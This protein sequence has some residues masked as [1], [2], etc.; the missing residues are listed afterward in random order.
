MLQLSTATNGRATSSRTTDRIALELIRHSGASARRFL[1]GSD[2]ET[3]GRIRLRVSSTDSGPTAFRADVL[4]GLCA[5]QKTIPCRW[6]YD[7]RGSEL[8]ETITRLPEYYPSRTE[9]AILSS[10]V[11]ALA[12]FVGPEAVVLEYGA[13][14]GIKSRMLLS[15]LRRPRLY[16]PID[17]AGEYLNATVKRMQV[18]FPTLETWPVV[19]DFTADFAMPAGLPGGRR[20][21]FFPGSTIGNLNDSEAGA[22]L[23]RMREHVGP[24]GAAII[25]VDM[26]KD[27]DELLTAYDDPAGVTAEFNLNLLTRINRELG[28]NFNLEAFTHQARW[29]A[30]A[31][32]IEMHL[33]SKIAQT[34][35]VDDERIEFEQGESIHTE[36][37][38][39]YDYQTF[40]TLAA[41][42]G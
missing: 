13:G 38:R 15:A 7:R 34:V 28:G 27:I 19:S 11:R 2:P 40:G 14:A 30:R 35:T 18:D 3:F 21:A 1:V 16:L 24:D 29:N 39:K 17:I 33:V 5:S 20:I 6:L 32:A 22:L 26:T 25:G 10:N 12:D 23:R 8:F 9:A 4:E 37:S 41:E 36:S 42:N 31:S